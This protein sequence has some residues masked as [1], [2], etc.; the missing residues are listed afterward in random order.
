MA[1][2]A[3]LDTLSM[4]SAVLGGAVL[5]GGGGGQLE[6]GLRLGQ[7]AAER[8]APALVDLD[9]LPFQANL[10]VISVFHTSAVATNTILP[11]H[12]HRAL[13]LLQDNCH[14]TIA[15]LVNG[16]YGAVN[17]LIGWDLAGSLQIPFVDAG[18]SSRL[19]LE[20]TYNLLEC[21]SDYSGI[22]TL[23]IVGTP[24]SVKHRVETTC[25]GTPQEL[26]R[27]L[28]QIATQ[29]EGSFAAVIGP[30]P[31]QW[32]AAHGA[33]G[34]VSAA[35]SVGRVM[36]EAE[37][38]GGP[39]IV[40]AVSR[41]LGGQSIAFGTVVG[42]EQQTQGREVYRLI[43]LR[44]ESNRLLELKWQHRYASLAV[45]GKKVATFPQLIVT[46]GSKGTPLTG[47]EVSDGQEIY[48][49]SV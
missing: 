19:H 20:P 15:G 17:T 1:L 42:Q 21:W 11:G 49:I 44:D 16:G 37:E 46:L 25:Q 22:L 33:S 12:S 47:E 30:V 29:F 27:F 35:L 8:G 24:S 10:A 36:I 6:T 26:G 5:G 18:I 13:E 41:I 7:H 28:N 14:Q 40:A 3:R 4:E 34:V 23:T 45:D 32:L 48:I 2:K 39:A 31:K 9:S 43:W 38:K